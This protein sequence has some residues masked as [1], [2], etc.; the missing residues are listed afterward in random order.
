MGGVSDISQW[1][2]EKAK[3]TLSAAQKNLAIGEWGTSLNRSYYAVFYA[4]QAANSLYSFDSKKHAGVR[5]FF[6]KTFLK[7]GLLDTGLSDI[8]NET[9]KYRE[10][11]DYEDMYEATPEA[12]A[13]Q[14]RNAETF[15]SAVAA[16]LRTI[17]AEEE[18]P[19]KK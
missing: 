3:L 14:I 19:V 17:P 2:I 6:R 10:R 15:V 18:E 11:A 12:A 16:Y 9:L 8:I 5:A 7:T 13:E 1:R 4:M